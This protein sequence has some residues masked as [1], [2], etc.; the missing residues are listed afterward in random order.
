MKRRADSTMIRKCICATVKR[1]RAEHPK[2][3]VCDTLN[4]GMVEQVMA[5]LGY[6]CDEYVLSF[7]FVAPE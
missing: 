4:Q 5:E 1:R 2:R 6:G 3:I 7:A